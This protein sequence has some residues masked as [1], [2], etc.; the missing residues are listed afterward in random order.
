MPKADAHG[1]VRLRGSAIGRSRPLCDIQ[2]S[3]LNARKRPSGARLRVDGHLRRARI[4]AAPE[5]HQHQRRGLGDGLDSDRKPRP[6]VIAAIPA[7]TNNE[8]ERGTVRCCARVA[9]V[10]RRPRRRALPPRCASGLTS[11]RAARLTVSLGRSFA[12]CC[13]KCRNTTRVEGRHGVAR[14]GLAAN[15]PEPSIPSRSGGNST[16][17][18]SSPCSSR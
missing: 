3:K 2:Q 6:I 16:V 11:P 18:E 17:P 10:V 4:W 7:I 14:C 1:N 13:P 9:T 15:R 5:A 12:A 8:V